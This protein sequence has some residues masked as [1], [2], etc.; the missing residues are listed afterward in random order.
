VRLRNLH[1]RHSIYI[2]VDGGELEHFKPLGEVLLG[3]PR[4]VLLVEFPIGTR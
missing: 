4:V 3:E 2:G 1:G